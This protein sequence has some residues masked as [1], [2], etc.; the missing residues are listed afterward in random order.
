MK[1]WEAPVLEDSCLVLKLDLFLLEGDALMWSGTIDNDSTKGKGGS[2]RRLQNIFDLGVVDALDFRVILECRFLADVL[3]D[4]E[5]RLVQGVLILFPADIMHD[6][7]SRL[8]GSLVRL[9]LVH[10]GRCRETAIAGVFVVVEVGDHVVGLGSL[11]ARLDFV[12]V[13]A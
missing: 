11:K 4:L 10:V 12:V 7:R 5:T 2:L 1:I 8:G 13:V 6:Y 3:I 9:R